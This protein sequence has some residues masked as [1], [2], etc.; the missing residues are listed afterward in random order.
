M[1][2][3]LEQ[4]YSLWSIHVEFGEFLEIESEVRFNIEKIK[5]TEK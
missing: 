2:Q 3:Q 5:M 4:P 1:L